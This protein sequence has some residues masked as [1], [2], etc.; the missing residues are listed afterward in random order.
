VL[1]ALLLSAVA[2]CGSLRAEA[3]SA[4]AL[5]SA[6]Y[7]S[8]NINIETGS[9]IARGG[10]L[11]VSYSRGPGGPSVAADRAERIVWD[12]YPERFGA[13]QIFQTPGGCVGP[14]CSSQDVQLAN[15]SYQQLRAELG[16]RPRSL[17]IGIAASAAAIPRWT[18]WLALGA[19]LAVIAAT[20]LLLTLI[21]RR[22]KRGRAG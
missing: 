22:P 19:A 14:V 2:A 6:G 5:N 4:A 21:L 3:T 15:A 1:L 10:L 12:T 16:P 9:G 17:H 8:V 13:L 7:Q 18:L 11:T 20:A